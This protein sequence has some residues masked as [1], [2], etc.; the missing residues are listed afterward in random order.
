MKK[1][2]IAAL[3]CAAPAISTAQEAKDTVAARQGFY[4]LLGAN[5]GVLSGMAKG[6]M[7]YTAEGAQT[8]ADNIALLTQYNMMHL[9][10]PGTSS[11]DV[12]GTR[13]LPAIWEDMAGVQEKGAAFKAA[14][15]NMQSV[16]G[17]GKDQMAGALGQLGGA[18]KSCHDDYRAK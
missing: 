16:A 12:E 9:F 15:E 4:K 1:L 18:C 13:A 11:A 10:A 8:A 17:Q 2:V 3:I 5:M 7:D 14:A 6:E